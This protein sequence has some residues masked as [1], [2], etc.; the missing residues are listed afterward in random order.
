MSQIPDT[1]YQA[2]DSDGKTIDEAESLALLE[3]K[4]VK[5]HYEDWDSFVPDIAFIIRFDGDIETVLSETKLKNFIRNLNRRCT[6][7]QRPVDGMTEAKNR[8]LSNA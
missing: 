4:F 7:E 6:F 8:E 1:V 5:S 3:D 2:I